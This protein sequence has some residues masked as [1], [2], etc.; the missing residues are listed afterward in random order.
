MNVPTLIIARTDAHGASFV[1]SD[2]D[3]LDQPFLNKKRSSEGF[4]AINAGISYA[5]ARALAYAPYADVIWCETST[6]DLAEAEKFAEGIH[7]KY[8]GKWLAYNC[9]PSFNWK[10]HLGEKELEHFQEQ[11]AKWGYK[12]QFVT[13]AGFHALNA[14]MFDLAVNYKKEGISAYAD[15]QE[16]EFLLERDHGFR[17]IKHQSFV[18][19]GYFD[20]VLLTVTERQS[21]TTALKGST[22]E[23]QFK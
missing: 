5:I 16:K 3:P 7:A 2:A 23:H 1:R 8:P 10:K 9:S 15:F 4:Y 14:G 11:L 21:N 17:G 20:E 22:E 13:L 18:G 6:P 12:F 19:A